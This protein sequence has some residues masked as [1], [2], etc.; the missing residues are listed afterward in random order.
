MKKNRTIPFGYMM[1]NGE[2]HQESAESKAVQEIFRLYLDGNSLLAIA[3]MMS[4]KGVSYNGINTVWNKNMVKRILEN[5]KYIGRNGY[6]IYVDYE[7]SSWKYLNDN[8]ANSLTMQDEADIIIKKY[9]YVCKGG[10]SAFGGEWKPK[11]ENAARFYG[12]P[13]TENTV[14][15]NK[16]SY[17]VLDYYNKDGKAVAERHLTDQGL[18]NTV[19]HMIIYWTGQKTFLTC[20]HR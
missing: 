14:R 3:S 10:G 15:T 1:K 13:Y 9:G 5:E 2:I 18:T 11:D 20:V 7:L 16:G 8:K 6:I 4:S 19:T 12:E 17:K